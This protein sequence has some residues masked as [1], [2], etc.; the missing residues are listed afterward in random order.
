MR[1]LLY[2]LTN[3]TVVRTMAEAQASGLEYSVILEEIAEA[4]SKMTEKQ[5]A[6]R[7]AIR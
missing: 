6:N 7:K 1:R 4:P 2:K 5:K 3:G